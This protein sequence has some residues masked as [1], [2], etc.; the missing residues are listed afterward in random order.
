MTTF[1]T[2]PA[3]ALRAGPGSHGP[4]CA[5]PAEGANPPR[6]DIDHAPVVGPPPEDGR[7][8]TPPS[9]AGAASSPF[10]WPEPDWLER[11]IKE[12]PLLP[13][14]EI[15]ERVRERLFGRNP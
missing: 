9:P 10:P 2:L 13:D 12:H 7:A 14:L 3:P 6:R 8:G 11:L 5:T 4:E 1:S 15:I